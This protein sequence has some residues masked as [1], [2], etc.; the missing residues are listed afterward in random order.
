MV[1]IHGWSEKGALATLRWCRKNDIPAVV[2]SESQAIDRSRS[3]LREFIKK[4]VIKNF[5]CGLCGGRPHVD[6]LVNLGMPED[7]IFT[8]YDVVDNSFF[9]QQSEIARKNERELRKKHNL[10]EKYFL[11]SGRFIRKKNFIRLLQAYAGYR[12]QGAV[13]DWKLVLLGAGELREDITNTV[14]LLN[15]EDHVLLPGFKQ[16]DDLP[17]YYGLA[18]VFIHCSTTNNGV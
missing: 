11:A 2:M 8:G 13:D 4:I 14:K 17:V 9:T 5:S 10:P 7:N 6:Y 12:K 3:F 16:Y 1:V 15:L 18:K